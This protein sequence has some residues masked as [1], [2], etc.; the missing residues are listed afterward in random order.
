MKKRYLKKYNAVCQYFYYNEK[1]DLYK[2]Y[3]KKLKS[4]NTRLFVRDLVSLSLEFRDEIY[5]LNERILEYV[6]NND[7]VGIYRL[8]EGV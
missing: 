5:E 3:Y 2:L 1:Y 8:L 6:N 7:E 4:Y